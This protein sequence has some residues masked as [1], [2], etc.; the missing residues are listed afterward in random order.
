MLTSALPPTASNKNFLTKIFLNE[1]VT[2]RAEGSSFY[3]RTE[4]I[5]VKAGDTILSAAAYG[6]GPA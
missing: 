3:K 6:R 5:P 1:K 4:S 2:D